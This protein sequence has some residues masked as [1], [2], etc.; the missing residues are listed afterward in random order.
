MTNCINC[1]APL[2]GSKCEYCGTEHDNGRRN[3]ELAELRR[4]VLETKLVMQ[5]EEINA[6]INRQIAETE[7]RN[8]R[9]KRRK[10]RA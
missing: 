3:V 6:N 4:T 8:A 10:G 9:R 1:G 5:M 7:N 2:R